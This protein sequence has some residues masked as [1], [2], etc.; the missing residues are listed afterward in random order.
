METTEILLFTIFAILGGLLGIII[1]FMAWYIKRLTYRIDILV[2]E[3][4]KL[5]NRLHQVDKEFIQKCTEIDE[6][7]KNME[8][9]V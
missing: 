4:S 1:S 3:I 6:R 8:K 7:L 9:N 2:K 5:N